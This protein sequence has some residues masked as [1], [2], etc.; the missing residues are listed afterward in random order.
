MRAAPS[1]ESW[2]PERWVLLSFPQLPHSRLPVHYRTVWYNGKLTKTSPKTLLFLQ[3]LG[4]SF[5]AQWSNFHRNTVQKA[6]AACSVY[7]QIHRFDKCS[8]LNLSKKCMFF[9]FTK[10]KVFLY[11][12]IERKEKGTSPRKED[13][14]T[15]QSRHSINRWLRE[16]IIH[17][18]KI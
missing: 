13:M 2:T 11:S 12:V 18:L 1:V 3:K 7:G 17:K 4:L 8:P 10:I 14:R 16:L 15:I 6:H 9:F 5:R